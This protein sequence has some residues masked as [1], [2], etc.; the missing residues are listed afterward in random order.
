MMGS[1]R[2]F[3]GQD[4]VSRRHDQQGETNLQKLDHVITHNLRGAPRIFTP[5]ICR[6]DIRVTANR[7]RDSTPART[8]SQKRPRSGRCMHQRLLP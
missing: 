5:K 8:A 1:F 6:A 3:V 4:L 2:L 7:P